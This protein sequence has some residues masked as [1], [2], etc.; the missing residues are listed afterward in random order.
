MLSNQ[1]INSRNRKLQ[2][3]R[4]LKR[5]F[6]LEELGGNEAKNI[7]KKSKKTSR[8]IHDASIKKHLQ[9]T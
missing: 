8:T 5:S 3:K 9:L 4:F 2:D 6:G 1:K 7:F